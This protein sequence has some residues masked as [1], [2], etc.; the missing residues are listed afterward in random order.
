[1]RSFENFGDGKGIHI[2]DN[3]NQNPNKLERV[4][5]N[6]EKQDAMKYRANTNNKGYGFEQVLGSKKANEGTQH[7]RQLSKNKSANQVGYGSSPYEYNF[8]APGNY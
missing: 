3:T 4:R 2:V 5:Q 7:K 8:R 1:M 6:M